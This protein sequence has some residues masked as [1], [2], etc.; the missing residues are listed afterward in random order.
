M[1]CGV[2]PRHGLDPVLVWLWCRPAAAAP[3]QPL[4]WEP[5]YAM[6][7]ALKWKKKLK[8]KK[9]IVTV[10]SHHVS[11]PQIH[12]MICKKVFLFSFFFFFFFCYYRTAPVAYGGSQATGRIGA[13][14]A[15][16]HH[17][18]SNLASKLRLQPI[19]Q[20]MPDPQPT[21]RGQGSSP[22]PHVY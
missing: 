8:L 1:S 20:L 14:A 19:P 22:H 18:H 10:S 16:L 6:G 12:L 2:G 7:V 11:D 13:I 17:S 3:T 15:S 21:E 4:A 5:P 9:R